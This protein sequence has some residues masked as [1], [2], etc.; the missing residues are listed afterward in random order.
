MIRIRTEGDSG[1]R[2][3]AG[4]AAVEMAVVMNFVMVPLMIGIWE[5]GRMVQLQMIVANAAREGA[6]LA[7]Q[8]L[9]VNQ[10]G[11]PTQ[12]YASVNPTGNQTTQTPNVKAAVMQSLYGAGLTTLTYNGTSDDVSVTFQ[13]LDG[14]TSNTDPY[15]GTKNQTFSVTVTIANTPGGAQSLDKVKWIKFGIVNPTSIGYTV[16]WKCLVDDA[17]VVNPTI[18]TY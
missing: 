8:S 12:I 2:R 5:M 6:R 7:A 4:T 3:R 1:R 15:Q 10:T 18:P 13:F 11:S 14:T 16:T 17:F 9:I